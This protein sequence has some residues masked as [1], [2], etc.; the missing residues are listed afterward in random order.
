MKGKI[1]DQTLVLREYGI[2]VYIF[3]VLSEIVMF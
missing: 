3:H 2:Q 1:D